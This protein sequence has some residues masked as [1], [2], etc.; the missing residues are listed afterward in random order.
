MNSVT[1]VSLIS[2][3]EGIRSRILFGTVIAA[4]F[5]MVISVLISG[6]FMRDISKVLLDLCLSTSTLCGLL[7]PFFFGG[8]LLWKDIEKKTIYCILSK[9][10]SRTEYI[11]GKHCALSLLSLSILS[12]FTFFTIAAVWLG[13][14]I[15]GEIYFTHVSITAII[16]AVWLSF[17]GIMVLNSLVVLW[18]SI[19][20][21]GFIAML[22]TASSY[23]IGHTVDDVV[24]FFELEAKLLKISTFGS[25]LAWYLQYIFP[26]L[27][28]FD[29]KSQAAYGNTIDWTELI[30]LTTYSGTYQLL[31]VC[32][33][34]LIFMKREVF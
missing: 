29:L 27:S 31:I 32:L 12:L 10:I 15:Y 33:A 11:L 2:Y 18:F 4:I 30:V 3:K 23:I 6:F 5:M 21:S 25:K 20:T 16:Q 19:T 24:A 14:F 34:I 13:K 28:A 7:V 1:A 22:L 17:C 9:N 26:N 8:Q